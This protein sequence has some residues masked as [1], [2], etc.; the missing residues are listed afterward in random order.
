MKIEPIDATLGAKITDVDLSSLDDGETEQIRA[1]FLEFA[2][3]I[4]PDQNLSEDEQIR[5]G[6]LFGQIEEFGSGVKLVPISNQRKDGSLLQDDE[7]TTKI[8]RGNEGWHTDSSYMPLAAK[9]SVLSAHVVPLEGGE[10]EWA[11]MR[12]AYEVL[13]AEQ[14]ARIGKLSAYHSLYYSQ[15]Q[16]GH[17]VKEGAGYGFHGDDTPLRPLLKIHPETGNPSLFVGRH[18]HEIPGLDTKA[19][20]QLLNDLVT[21]ACQ[22]PRTYQHSWRPGDIVIW[23]NRC[24][25]HRAKPYNHNEARVMKHTRIAGDPESELAA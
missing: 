6:E 16:I 15:A 22:S 8:L 13:N 1:S 24:L 9:A 17:E 4:F 23:D 21:N 18:A 25:L 14:K 2:L 19:S 7:H 10:T 3:L 20:S 12:A 5:F 11:D